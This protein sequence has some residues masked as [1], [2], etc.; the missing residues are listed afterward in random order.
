MVVTDNALFDILR[1]DSASGSATRIA[2]HDGSAGCIRQARIGVDYLL[3]HLKALVAPMRHTGCDSNVVVP[4]NLTLEIDF[5]VDYHHTEIALLWRDGYTR[6]GKI[7]GFSKVEEFHDDS[8]ID[9]A[10]HVDI[11][12]TEL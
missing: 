8:V 6:I 5:K 10:H 1:D 4:T 12:E 2:R 9:M 7:M 3:G 11:I